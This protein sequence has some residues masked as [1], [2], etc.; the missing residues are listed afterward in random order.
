[1]KT[2]NLEIKEFLGIVKEVLSGF[3]EKELK[4]EVKEDGVGVQKDDSNFVRVLLVKK[5]NFG[6]IWLWSMLK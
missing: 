3:Q 4:F 2:L 6:L 5:F 1:M